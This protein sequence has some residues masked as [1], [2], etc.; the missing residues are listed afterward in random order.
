MEK[1]IE[2][3]KIFK[4]IDSTNDQLKRYL[5]ESS[6]YKIVL[7][8]EQTKGKGQKDNTFISPP[9]GLYLSIAIQP[10]YN[11]DK[12][13]YL[14]V[15]TAIEVKEVLENLYQKEIQLKWLNDIILDEKKLGGILIENK[16]NTENKLQFTII[17]IGINLKNNRILNENLSNKYTSLSISNEQKDINNIL[18][19]LVPAIKSLENDF[20]IPTIINKY[21]NNL[22]LKNK[23]ISLEGCS[24]TYSGKL[25]SVNED[26]S[27][28]LLINNKIQKFSYDHFHILDPYI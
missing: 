2:E 20:D 9:G 27:I 12:L 28:N 10:K 15:R 7:A 1:W 13:K 5:N 3:I 6:K 11:L 22:F 23:K 14:S 19:K 24:Q 18:Y 26:L 17:G 21:N 16:F 8:N 25:L 4:K